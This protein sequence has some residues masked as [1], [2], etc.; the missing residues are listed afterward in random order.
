MSESAFLEVDGARLPVWDEYSV[1]S[2]LFSPADGFSFG[3]SLPSDS[4]FSTPRSRAELREKLKPGRSVKL[5]VGDDSELGPET[6]FLQMTG[7]IDDADVTATRDGGTVVKVQGR[8]VAGYLVDASVDLRIAVTPEMKLLDLIRVAVEPWDIDVLA[9]SFA[10]SETLRGNSRQRAGSRQRRGARAAGI[11][12]DR[13]SLSAQA[14]ADRTGRPIEEVVGTAPDTDP[15]AAQ[16]RLATRSAYANGL[17][18]SDIARLKVSDAR[19]QVGETVWA[20]IDRHCKRLGVMIW[21]APEGRLIVSSPHYTQ[22]PS[23]SAVRRYRS[24]A[25]QPNNVLDGSVRQSI[26]ERVSKVTV[27]GRGNPRTGSRTI[28]HGVAVDES[29]PSPFPKEMVIQ[30]TAIK[31]DAEATRRA[32]REL[33]QR[34]QQSFMLEYELQGHGQGPVIYSIDTVMTVVD[35][36]ADVRGNFYV[37]RRTFQRSR[38]DGTKTSIQALPIGAIVF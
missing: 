9:D 20:F 14:E 13:Y 8:D 18:P 19:P 6:R 11:R 15:A 32:V 24:D 3:V 35:D 5:Y 34:K 23:F 33:N 2:D 21:F 38:T 7:F 31:T 16:A 29:W 36:A 37:T 27:Y 22:D 17:S 28:P 30:D 10:A 4:R 26:G 1:D 12:A 25:S